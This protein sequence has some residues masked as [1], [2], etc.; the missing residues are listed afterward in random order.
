MNTLE[1]YQQELLALIPGSSV[2]LVVI[3]ELDADYLSLLGREPT[4]LISDI[5]QYQ[6]NG[7]GM[8]QHASVFVSIE[9]NA[10]AKLLGQIGRFCQQFPD[11]VLIELQQVQHSG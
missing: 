6:A 3:G 9:T 4:Q 5:N 10:I 11:Q 2:S 7:R 8:Q 1:Q